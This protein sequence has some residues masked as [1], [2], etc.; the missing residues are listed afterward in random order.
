MKKLISLALVLS[1]V[2]LSGVTA[3]ASTDSGTVGDLTW[4]FDS[5][6][7]VLTVSGSGDM[8]SFDTSAPWYGYMSQIKKIVV[9]NGVTS[10]SDNAFSR[11]N[12][13]ESVELAD[14]VTA[15]GAHAFEQTGTL[16]SVKLGTGLQTI[17]EFAFYGCYSLEAVE[18]PDGV[19]AV[20]E[21]AFAS[22]NALSEV[23]LPDTVEF[24]G[25]GAF[26][27]C[28][29]LKSVR[30][31]GGFGIIG[32]SAFTGCASLESFTIPEGIVSV[33]AQA[34]FDCTSLKWISIPDSVDE[35]DDSALAYCSALETVY[36]YDDLRPSLEA[37]V[38][39]VAVDRRA[40]AD[41]DNSGFVDAL[42][43]A[44]VKRAVLG[45][46][47]IVSP[48]LHVADC[49]KDSVVDAL[50]YA[51]LKRAVLGTVELPSIATYTE[52]ELM[53]ATWWILNL[54]NHPANSQS[55]I[56]T[57]SYENLSPEAV[58]QVVYRAHFDTIAEYEVED[59]SCMVYI[60][61]TEVFSGLATISF[62]YTYDF[63]SLHAYDSAAP[64]ATRFQYDADSDSVVISIEAM[65]W[66]PESG[67][68]YGGYEIWSAS[69]ALV[70]IVYN[71]VDE[72]TGEV[73]ST[74][75]FGI[76]KIKKMKDGTLRYLGFEYWE[77]P[78]V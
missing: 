8:P 32:E 68:D 44:L 64:Y 34:F 21:Y 60:V 67:Y 72:E 36:G 1:L 35:F 77:Y 6:T 75:D 38:S 2:A 20:C 66:G 48:L 59:E 12:V 9:K 54:A 52:G 74:S 17:A 76:L 18:L 4:S 28:R 16:N 5:A 41:I 24:L 14:S 69:E 43:Y 25:M 27:N 11:G 15:I 50:D 45:T 40:I 7:G 26:A 73:L 78:C 13:L 58:S 49:N 3:F 53:E 30:L 39:F 33:G 71:T 56:F 46:Y 42:D 61:P 10:I 23:V 29:G 37:G 70:N 51:F 63:T 22:C 55:E 31:G 19:V 57:E 47:D 65:G 62:G